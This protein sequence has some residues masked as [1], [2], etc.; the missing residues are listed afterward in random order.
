MTT[1]KIDCEHCMQIMQTT[2][3]NYCMPMVMGNVTCRIEPG[4]AG[5]KADPDPIVCDYYMPEVKHEEK[6]RA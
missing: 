1:Y 3:G 5:T 4:H 2:N 6:R